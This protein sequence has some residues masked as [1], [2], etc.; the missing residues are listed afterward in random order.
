MS[1][2]EVLEV[3]KDLLEIYNDR[4]NASSAQNALINQLEGPF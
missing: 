1:K 2:I 4:I 3:K